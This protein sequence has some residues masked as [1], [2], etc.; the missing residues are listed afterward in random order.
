MPPA[1]RSIASVLLG[2]MAMIVLKMLL[3]PVFVR[4]MGAGTGHPVSPVLFFGVYALFT[5]VA[6]TAGGFVTAVTA[7]VKPID[8]AAALGALTCIVGFITYH[9]L[10]GGPPSWYE[11]MIGIAPA[12]CIL[13]GAAFYNPKSA[14]S[15][16]R[17]H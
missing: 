11:W 2:F 17:V 5:F 7:K 13:T 15:E 12:F 10:P 9:H 6:A 3:T 16:N 1:L 8:H 14:G 4:T